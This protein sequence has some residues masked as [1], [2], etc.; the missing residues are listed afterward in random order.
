MPRRCG[1][2][3]SLRSFS[4]QSHSHCRQLVNEVRGSVDYSLVSD[5]LLHR[6]TSLKNVFWSLVPPNLVPAPLSSTSRIGIF[7]RSFCASFQCAN[8][9]YLSVEQVIIVACVVVCFYLYFEF[10]ISSICDRCGVFGGFFVFIWTARTPDLTP[11]W[12]LKPFCKYLY[13]FWY[14]DAYT[15]DESL[16]IET[17]SQ[18][19][20]VRIV[21]KLSR[22]S[23]SSRLYS[24]MN[25]Q[26][27][28][29]LIKK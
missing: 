8:S 12:I 23:S 9:F 27:N 14:I 18:T 24:Q 5:R 20:G 21:F 17:R 26:Q 7:S 13:L 2:R 1:S 22:T 16:K 4:V 29:D 28:M 15:F 6:K 3:P 19:K 10:F 25:V 11:T